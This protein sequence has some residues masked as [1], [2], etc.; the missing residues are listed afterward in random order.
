MS[1]TKLSV[2]LLYIKFTIARRELDFQRDDAPVLCP[3]IRAQVSAVYFP[4]HSEENQ[5]STR[6]W[7]GGKKLIL[8]SNAAIRKQKEPTSTLKELKKGSVYRRGDSGE[9]LSSSNKWW[10]EKSSNVIIQ[11]FCCF[12]ILFPISYLHHVLRSAGFLCSFP[13]NEKSV[14][15][16]PAENFINS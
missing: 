4:L 5:Y 7:N 2:F 15:T 9:Y 11:W 3:A 6:G 10:I 1:C 8:R 13:S 12:S 16:F 14:E